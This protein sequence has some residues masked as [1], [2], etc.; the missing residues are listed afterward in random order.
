MAFLLRHIARYAARKIASD[1]VARD[2]A[3]R[4][5][6]GIAKEA[7]QIATDQ[8]PAKAAGRAMRRALNKLQDN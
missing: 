1:P 6:R 4:A 7:K 2:K 8:D 3:S 5:A